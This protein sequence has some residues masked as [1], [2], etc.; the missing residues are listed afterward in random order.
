MFLWQ[1]L[2]AVFFSQRKS[3][4]VVVILIAV[5][6]FLFTFELT[7]FSLFGFSLVLS[8]SCLSGIRWTLAQ[9]VMQRSSLG[10]TYFVDTVELILFFCFF[11]PKI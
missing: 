10:K 1:N 8:A 5:G 9:L 2:L 6:L 4:V 11:F 7:Q 3:I